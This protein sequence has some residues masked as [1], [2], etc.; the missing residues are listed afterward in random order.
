VRVNSETV[1]QE[2]HFWGEC[3]WEQREG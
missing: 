3:R 1:D 2:W